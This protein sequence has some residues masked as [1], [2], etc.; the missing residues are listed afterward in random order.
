MHDVIVIGAGPGGYAAAIRTSQLG[1]KVVLVEAAEVGGTCVNRGCIPSKVL[2][3]AVSL[4]HWIRTGKEFGINAS[5]EQLDLKALIA[6]KNGVAGD[7]RVGMESLLRN[8]GVEFIKG[9]ALLKSP[10]EVNVN[11]GV[12]EAKKI[13]LSTGSC[14]DV[15]DIPGLEEA[16]LTTDQV[17]EMTEVPSSVLIW[18]F[19]GSIEVEMATLLNAFGSKVYLAT[20]HPRI[21]PREDHGTSLR[22]AQSLREQGVKLLPRFN[23]QSVRKSKEGY[24]GVLSGPEE[25]AVVVERVLVSSRRPKTAPLGLE[26]VGVRLNE[27]GSIKVNNRLETS[28]EGIY[29]IGDATGGWMLSHAAS[30]MAVTAAENA[31]GKTNTFSFHLIPRGIWTFP[32]VGAVGLSEEEAE[33]RGM[34]IE[35]GNFPY[36][37][38]GLAMAR[39]EM[40]GAVKIISDARYGEILGVHIVG[41]NA[42]ELVGEAVLAMQLEAT[43]RELASSIRVHPTFSEA[44]VDSARVAENWALYLPKR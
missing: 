38:N 31:M 6:R 29:A 14:L 37:I 11:G 2:M 24:E 13:I 28:V 17:F 36:S 7:I 5:V 18:G 42:T 12:L 39:N 1:G 43:V 30:S 21:L 16:A 20:H 8:N 44:M 34:E 23:L 27:D 41:S 4:L 19:A 25:H 9:R 32:E 35:V 22:I 3:R 15:P 10:R 26:Q 40:S 33:K